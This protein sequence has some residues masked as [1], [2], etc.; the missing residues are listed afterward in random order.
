MNTNRTKI[1]ILTKLKS[2][3]GLETPSDEINIQLNNLSKEKSRV[4]ERININSEKISSLDAIISDINKIYELAKEDVTSGLS[5]DF[6]TKIMSH[7][8]KIERAKKLNE[9]ISRIVEMQQKHSKLIEDCTI[10]YINTIINGKSYEYGQS[11]EIAII[12]NR[13]SS[14]LKNTNNSFKSY[15]ELEQIKQ[16]LISK[17]VPI[18]E[19]RIRNSEVSSTIRGKIVDIETSEEKYLADYAKSIVESKKR[20]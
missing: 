9:D 5:N 14:K 20:K 4:D 19:T 13:I 16:N 11:K 3:L 8:L 2:S 17:R 15:N 7:Q 18:E 6:S 10:E 1:N 12:L